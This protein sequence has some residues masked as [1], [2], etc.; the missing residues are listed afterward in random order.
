MALLRFL[1]RAC[2]II[3]EGWG[4]PSVFNADMVVEELVRQGKR[5]EDARM[6][7]TSGCVETGAFGKEAYILT[8]SDYF[9]DLT[10]PLQDE[11]IAR[12]EH[13]SF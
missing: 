3:A 13:G 4:Q 8:D 10:R 1:T 5:I 11:I 6:G 7:R 12:T 2:A 9:C